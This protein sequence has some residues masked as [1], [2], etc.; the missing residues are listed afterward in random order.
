MSHF[1]PRKDGAFLRIFFNRTMH[2]NVEI[3][4]P[5]IKIALGVRGLVSNGS[6][7]FA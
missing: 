5:A 1:L 3:Y 6:F 7:D 2:F 4:S